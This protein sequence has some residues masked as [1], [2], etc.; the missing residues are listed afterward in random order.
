MN[1]PQKLKISRIIPFG[2]L[3]KQKKIKQNKTNELTQSNAYLIEAH[4]RLQSL[5]PPITIL[6][7]DD[8]IEVMPIND[9]ED[10]EII[11]GII[12]NAEL[13]AQD[14]I[15]Q[16]QPRDDE[17]MTTIPNDPPIESDDIIEVMPINDHED[18]EI[19]S[20]IIANAELCAQD[21][22]IQFQPR[23]DECM[24][25]IPND[26]PIE[27]DDIIEV[28]PINDDEDIE[29]ISRIIANAE[30][31]AQ[32]KVIQF[33]P[34]DDECMTLSDLYT[35]FIEIISDDELTDND[36]M[37][38]YASY[39]EYDIAPSYGG[40][41]LSR[42]TSY[43]DETFY[44]LCDKYNIF[45]H[46]L[47]IKASYNVQHVIQHNKPREL[48]EC[49][50]KNKPNTRDLICMYKLISYCIDSA[51]NN[52]YDG[53]IAQVWINSYNRVNIW[54]HISPEPPLSTPSHNKLKNKLKTMREIILDNKSFH[55]TKLINYTNTN[56]SNPQNIIDVYVDELATD[57][58]IML[59][60]NSFNKCINVLCDSNGVVYKD[61][62]YKDYLVRPFDNGSML[63]INLAKKK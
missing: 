49:V 35:D 33:R 15:I 61:N 46:Q 16:F 32:D 20:G 1:P 13:C 48:I 21:K 43:S 25:T 40:K 37:Q 51:I 59:C 34:R 14:K 8:I 39:T 26:P 55:I 53:L 50:Y 44:E 62:M 41:I 2:K 31:S 52:E 7:S 36:D 27:S 11:S 23:D 5:A 29:I 63:K 18:I 17:C 57:M 10:I 54:Y 47:G 19:I 58:C 22:I 6:E 38:S 9:H 28:M 4:K 56:L 45:E 3:A 30:L 42:K 24:T 60:I 12:A